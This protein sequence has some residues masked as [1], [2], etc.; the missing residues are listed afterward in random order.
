MTTIRTEAENWTKKEYMK[1]LYSAN[2]VEQI[3]KYSVPMLRLVN[4][5]EIHRMKSTII[6]D[7]DSVIK[8][9]KN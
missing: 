5:S 4:H 7:F 6:A 9:L 1:Q 2:L 3:A 8:S